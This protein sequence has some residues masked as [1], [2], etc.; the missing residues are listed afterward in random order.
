MWNEHPVLCKSGHMRIVLTYQ[1]V[2]KETA[3]ADFFFLAHACIK[4]LVPSP[5]VDF[6]MKEK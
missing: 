5:G 1:S 4:G 3:S 2:G 6:I